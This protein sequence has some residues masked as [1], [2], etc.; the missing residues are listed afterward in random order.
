MSDTPPKEK[1][2]KDTVNLPRTEFPMKGNLAQLEPRMLSW[3]AE[4]GIW[5]RILEKNAAAEPFVLP[6]GPPYANGHLHAGHALNRILKD[7]VVKYRNM[8]G[9]KCDFI[10]GWDTHGLPIEQAVEKRL[11]DKKIDKRTLSRDAFLEACRAYALEFIEIQKGEAQRM[12]TFAS[13][14]QPYR[15]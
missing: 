12:G 7:V 3:W 1:D 10:P 4:R 8:S 14:E 2:Y 15:T 5:G 11:K 9:R 6:D 13:W